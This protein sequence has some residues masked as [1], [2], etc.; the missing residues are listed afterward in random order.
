MDYT[1]KPEKPHILP[2]EWKSG[3][4]GFIRVET[5][6]MLFGPDTG[7]VGRV[8][9]PGSFRAPISGF[10]TG[11]PSSTGNDANT[12]GKY[13][14]KRLFLENIV[15]APNSREIFKSGHEYSIG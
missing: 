14:F 2:L 5:G 6:E 11:S 8:I 10:R 7:W 13:R 3:F 4:E 1:E 9:H 15:S 12:H